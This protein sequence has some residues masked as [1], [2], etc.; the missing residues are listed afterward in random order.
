[1]QNQVTLTEAA[2]YLGVSKATL[3]N[4]DHEG[5][6]TAVRNPVNGYRMYDLDKLIEFRKKDYGQTSAA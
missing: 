5:K 1:M 2:S 6:L 3:R 4:W